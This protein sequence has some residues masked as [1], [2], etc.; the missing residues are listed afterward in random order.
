[1]DQAIVSELPSGPAPAAAPP[2]DLAGLRR[3]RLARLRAEL[4][5][6]HLAGALLYDPVNIRYACDSRNMAVWTLHNPVRYVFV[7]TEGPVIV[8]DFHNCAHLSDGLETVDEVR[9]A[10][11]WTFFTAGPRA[12][13]RARVWAAE[14]ADLLAT[15]GGGNRRLALDR[16]DPPGLLALQALGVEPHDGQAVLEMA[17]RIKTAEE[18]ACMRVAIAVCEAAMAQMRGALRPGLT[19]NDLWAVLNQVNAARGGEWI[20]TR[21]LASGPRANPWFQESSDRVVQTGE[22]VSFDSDLIGPFGYCADIS[23]SY[24]CGPGRA[25]DAQRRLYRLAVEQIHA[26]MELLRPGL[27]FRELAESAWQLPASCRANR[28]S[29]IV[30]GVG[31]CDEYPHICYREDFAT[32]GYDGIIEPGMTLCVESYMGE[33]GGAEGVKLEQQVL[34]TESGVELLSHFPFEEALLGREV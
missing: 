31:L 33:E 13:E 11:S 2:I 8:F 7:A 12:A 22:L 30:H 27:S 15:Y 23:R 5:R 14:V 21:L 20:E 18:L 29:A 26:N 16:C 24:L 10:V 1:M 3:G 6:S 19:E 25:S 9:P 17:R 34:V 4:A 32:C 28:Y